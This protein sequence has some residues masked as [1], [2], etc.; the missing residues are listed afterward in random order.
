MYKLILATLVCFLI[1]FPALAETTFM[2][3]PVEC[4]AKFRPVYFAKTGE[5]IADSS[6]LNKDETHY[7]AGSS[8]VTQKWVNELLADRAVCVDGDIKTRKGIAPVEWAEKIRE[9]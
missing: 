6:P 1:S 9:P 3:W 4:D 5:T 7:M 2:M 8:R